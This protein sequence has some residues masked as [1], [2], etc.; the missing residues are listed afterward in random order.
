MWQVESWCLLLSWQALL[1]VDTLRVSKAD[2]PVYQRARGVHTPG[3]S[4]QPPRVAWTSE[5]ARGNKECLEKE[6][7]TLA[8]QSLCPSTVSPSTPSEFPIDIT[9]LSSTYDLSPLLVSTDISLEWVAVS[10]Y[11]DGSGIHGTDKH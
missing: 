6:T 3:C 11:S 8:Q 7:V 9:C 10:G 5:E 1:R 2:K 4:G